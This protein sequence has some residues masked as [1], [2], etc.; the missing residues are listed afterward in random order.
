MKKYQVK[1]MSCVMCSNTVEQEVKKFA[2]VKSAQINFASEKII[3]DVD[4]SFD[5]ASLIKHIASIGYELIPLEDNISLTIKVGGMSCVMCSK[6]I[7]ENLKTK[8]GIEY[9]SVS[10]A[11]EEVLVKFDSKII[12]Q[13][14]IEDVITNLGY[15][16]I[17]QK[18]IKDH[19]KLKLIISLGLSALLLLIAMG[20]MVG[21]KLPRFIDLNTSP[22]TFALVQMVL[23]MIVMFIGRAF[24]LKGYKNL[25]KLRPNMDSLVALGT[26]A[27]FL[28]SMYSLILIINNNHDAVHMLYFEATGVIIALILLGKYLEARSKGRA[29]DALDRLASLAPETAILKK[30]NTTLE[31]LVKDLAVG[32]I[33]IVSTGEQIPIDGLV[34]EGEASVDEAM[35]TGESLPV[36]KKEGSLVVGASVCLS[37]Y[38]LVKVT[39]IGKDTILSK[40]ITLVEEAQNTKAPIA[41]L[42]D[43]VSGIFVPIVLVISLLAGL[44]WYLVTKDF[45]FALKISVSVLVIA[46]PCSLGLAT[47][48]AI[49]VATGVGASHG[50]LLK[51]AEVLEETHKIK[52]IA[53]DKTGT[54]TSGE[55]SVANI[56]HLD[57]YKKRDILQL[58]ASLEV[59]STHPLAKAVVKEA[60]ID[61][62]SYL[63]TSDYHVVDGKGLKARIN[64]KEYLLG[65]LSLVENK[66]G[67]EVF[68]ND[69]KNELDTGKTIIILAENEQIIAFASLSD[70]IKESSFEGVR[71]LQALGLEVALISGDH[72]QATAEVATKLGINNYYYGVLPDKKAQILQELKAKYGKIA[73][74]GDGIN[75]SVALARA[76]IGMAMASGTQIAISSADIVLMKSDLRDVALA[77]YLSKKTIKNIKENLFWAFGYN[78]IGLPLAAGL[79]FPFF[80]LLLN[81]MIAALAMAFSSVSVVL[82]A[83]RLKRL[84]LNK[85]LN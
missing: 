4:E 1:G 62:L 53:L 70:T 32:D 60:K 63:K 30:D 8:Q 59:N 64:N 52:A 77:I 56:Y 34:I 28:Y 5:E 74:V 66:Q 23:A 27:S 25:F 22:L 80:G 33:I 12:T 15:Q 29:K 44:I 14:E 3:I 19:S 55:I 36:E 47:P 40:M 26:S 6:A 54:L 11:S 2:G 39:S 72:Q 41:R 68:K 42:A 82:N 57:T 9:V 20:P 50:I 7:E 85:K 65:N 10:F 75:D 24:Y 61:N 43:K 46:C 18:E 17:K 71:M 58:M 83:L 73:M 13:K 49:I 16:V 79:F 51:N 21:I 48:I 45:A 67:L 84:S 31:V 38:L 69:I 81:P 78:I 76:D 37:G 35:L